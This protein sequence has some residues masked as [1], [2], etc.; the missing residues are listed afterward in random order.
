MTPQYSREVFQDFGRRYWPHTFKSVQED[1]LEGAIRGLAE[2][3]KASLLDGYL[4]S[5]VN[6]QVFMFGCARWMHYGCPVVQY[7]GHRYAAALMAT[8][9]ATGDIRPPWKTFLIELP[10][11][12][13]QTAGP[14]GQLD[15]IAYV[16]VSQ[17]PSRRT[18][19]DTEF[20]QAWTYTAYTRSG[21]ALHQFRRTVDELR[22]NDEQELSG[23]FAGSFML[24]LSDEDS[25]TIALLNRLVL[26]TCTAMSDPE[27]VKPLGVPQ[28]KPHKSSSQRDTKEPDF[29]LFRVG[30]EVKMDCR[31]ALRAF[32]RGD[33]RGPLTVQFIVRGHWRH[34]PCGPQR[35]ERRTIWIE[36]YW[37]GP[38]DAAII[39][40][41]HVMGSV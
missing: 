7:T 36:P 17:Y 19:Q 20:F 14:S 34:Q 23:T 4:F 38:E 35:A 8:G 11:G 9:T 3:A 6:G 5:T 2:V 37:K 40:R 29:R 12:L 31:D 24:D 28:K 41:A 39:S 21:V 22:D 27:A 10:N 15:D 18:P 1:D 26:N 25:R 30:R 32:V 16:L 13:L 33:R